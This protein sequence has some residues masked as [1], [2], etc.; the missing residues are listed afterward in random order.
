MAATVR[1]L[2][3]FGASSESGALFANS[4]DDSA[5]QIERLQGILGYPPRAL[6]AEPGAPLRNVAVLIGVTCSELEGESIV[7]EFGR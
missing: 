2:A 1:A 5:R 3:I 7:A 4:R 6:P